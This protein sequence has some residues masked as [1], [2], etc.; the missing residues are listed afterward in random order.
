MNK[1][2]LRYLIQLKSLQLVDLSYREHNE[3]EFNELF[4]EIQ[5]LKQLLDNIGEYAA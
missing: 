2:E 5:H 1:V 3:Q 4:N